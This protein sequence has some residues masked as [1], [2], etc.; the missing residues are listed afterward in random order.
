MLVTPGLSPPFSFLAHAACAIFSIL[1]MSPHT[2]HSLSPSCDS[3]L[4]LILSSLLW[5]S[6]CAFK[7]PKLLNFG[8]IRPPAALMDLSH[9]SSG[10]KKAAPCRI[11]CRE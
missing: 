1:T 11:P 6:K 10:Q 3:T 7:A 9:P 8:P 4:G 2:T 5:T